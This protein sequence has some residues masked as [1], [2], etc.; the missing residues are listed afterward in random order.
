ML[1]VVLNR[2]RKYC[3]LGAI[4]INHSCLLFS[5][6]SQFTSSTFDSLPNSGASGGAHWTAAAPLYGRLLPHSRPL[7]AL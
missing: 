6:S 3:P 1:K 5:S 2:E 7:H 4:Y